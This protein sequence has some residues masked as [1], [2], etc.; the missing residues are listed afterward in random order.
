[1]TNKFMKNVYLKVSIRVPRQLPN[2]I[3][4]FCSG[5]IINSNHIITSSQCVH[6]ETNHLI[7]PEWFRIIA[8][9]IQFIMFVDTAMTE[10]IFWFTCSF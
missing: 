10:L 8:G 4:T 5:T 2:L 1:M 7:N 6:N 9:T 3:E